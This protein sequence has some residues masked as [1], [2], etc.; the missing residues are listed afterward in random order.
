M[1][2]SLDGAEGIIKGGVGQNIVSGSD[3]VNAVIKAME[4]GLPDKEVLLEFVATPK[5]LKS[6]PTIVHTN[7]SG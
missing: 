6:V 4:V 2:K 1:M 5:K 3:P 7:G